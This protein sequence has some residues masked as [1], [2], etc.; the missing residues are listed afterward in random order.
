MPLLFYRRPDYLR[1]DKAALTDADFADCLERAE[2]CKSFIPESLSFEE[3]VR[4]RTLPPCSLNDFM[5]YLMY[6]EYDAECLQFFLWYCDYVKRW[7]LLPQE[8]KDS[9]PTWDP[10]KVITRPGT[11]RPRANSSNESA[12]RM[13]HIL[14]ILEKS[15][16]HDGNSIASP[17]SATSTKNFSW[18]KSTF[19]D[20]YQITKAQREGRPFSVQPF[21]DEMTRI[22]RHYISTSGPRQ[23]N[24]THA[25]RIAC[26]QAVEQTT[27]PS[28]LLPALIAAE[29]LLKG[30]C[31][32]NFIKWSISN[33]SQPRVVFARWLAAVCILLGLGSNAA[34]ILSILSRFLRLLPSIFLFMGFIFLFASRHGVCVILHWNYK[35]NLRPWEQFADEDFTSPSGGDGD[36]P[37]VDTRDDEKRPSSSSSSF[38]PATRT[39]SI[40][41]LRKPSLQSLGSANS[42]FDSEPWV[43]K[44]HEKSTWRKI[45]DVSITIQNQHVRAMQDR[46]VRRAMLW[47]GFLSLALTAGAVSAP[48]LGLF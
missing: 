22:V 7:S 27:H 45:F 31:H 37:L 12:D 30:Q 15:P 11:A 39:A 48:V 3:I 16:R 46:I 1:R 33:S 17:S 28:A 36:E 41:P 19:S 44:Y 32:P 42:M 25:D 24:L 8:Q 43:E 47:S 5:D 21:R 34:L 38:S 14:E 20:E 40:D 6:V 2:S 4:N 35:R 23:L 18:P 10:N 9:S 26:I 29:T 13:N